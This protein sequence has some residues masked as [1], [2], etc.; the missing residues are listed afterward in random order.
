VRCAIHSRDTAIRISSVPR[1]TLNKTFVKV[2]SWD[3][4][5]CL[6]EYFPDSIHPR[7]NP[8]WRP[9]ALAWQ[10][11]P[12]GHRPSS[13]APC[14][15]PMRLSR[16]DQRI[17]DEPCT[18]Q[19]ALLGFFSSRCLSVS[20]GVRSVAPIFTFSPLVPGN[21]RRRRTV[22]RYVLVPTTSK[23]SSS[24]DTRRIGSNLGGQSMRHAMMPYRMQGL[25]RSS[26][27]HTGVHACTLC[28]PPRT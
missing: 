3:K 8:M 5:I 9:Q 7:Q 14:A 27:S 23:F 21:R 6:A 13:S 22:P 20:R 2:P 1:F 11:S 15:V 17:R 25:I 26:A 10:A 16:I 24:P 18:K 19:R 4:V 28:T 12:W